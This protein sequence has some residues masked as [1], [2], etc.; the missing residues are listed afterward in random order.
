MLYTLNYTK[1][2]GI[3]RFGG[4]L[5]LAQ[6]VCTRPLFSFVQC[7]ARP[8]YEASTDLALC[9]LSYILV[10]RVTEVAEMYGKGALLANIDIE[11][12]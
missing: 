11:A 4:F 1:V 10:E 8:G 7:T 12:A 3:P 9:S 6:T 2:Y 5:T